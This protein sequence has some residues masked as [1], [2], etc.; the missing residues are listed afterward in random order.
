V[1]EHEVP[2]TDTYLVLREIDVLCT[3]LV[4]DEPTLSTGP[5]IAVEE[6]VLAVASDH[7]LATRE[8][9]LF[10][11]LGGWPVCEPLG[12]PR[13][14]WDRCVPTA[15][16]SGT[17]LPRAFQV[18]SA[19]EIFAL[20]GR[21]KAVHPTVRSMEALYPRPGVV[22][23]PI[24]DMAPLPLG[25]IWVRAHENARIRAFAQVAETVAAGDRKAAIG[26]AG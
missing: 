7:P 4:F 9:V 6:R 3:W 15:T 26:A 5:V 2:L 1:I 24:A 10:E 25:L 11:D 12:L 21:G 19:N 17:P 16:P 20:V 23:I 14:V 18:T 8:E 22:F 13:P